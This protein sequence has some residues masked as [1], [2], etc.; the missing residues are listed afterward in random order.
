M[1]ATGA[2][3][4]EDV[5]MQSQFKHEH[6]HSYTSKVIQAKFTIVIRKT[7]CSFGSFNHE[8]FFLL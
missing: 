3:Q 4:N 2:A 7:V 5:N 8:N 6:L 1:T